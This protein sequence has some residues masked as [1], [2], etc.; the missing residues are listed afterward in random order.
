MYVHLSIDVSVTVTPGGR[1]H[2][3]Q[4]HAVPEDTEAQV[5]LGSEHQ[6]LLC[7][8]N[9]HGLLPPSNGPLLLEVI[10][11]IIITNICPVHCL[12]DFISSLQ[13]LYWMGLRLP[14]LQRGEVTCPTSQSW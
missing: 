4:P 13:Q 9:H 10:I 7:F 12:D 11:T 1:C 5:G 2:Y 3:T 14:G 8:L 6:C